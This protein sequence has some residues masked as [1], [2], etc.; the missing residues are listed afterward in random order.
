M[1]SCTLHKNA[2]KRMK[3]HQIALK[4]TVYKCYDANCQEVNGK[5]DDKMGKENTQ[6]MDLKRTKEML[7]DVIDFAT[8]KVYGSELVH[9]L[10]DKGYT[11]EERNEAGLP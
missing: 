10:E 4:F 8:E 9:F 1:N 6:P 2:Q 11:E 3:S 5:A 7:K